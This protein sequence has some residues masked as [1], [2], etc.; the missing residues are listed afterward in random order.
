MKL[1]KLL[2]LNINNFK[3][4]KSADIDFSDITKISG[5]NELGKS[6]I[7]DSFYWLIDGKDSRGLSEFGIKMMDSNGNQ[8][9]NLVIDVKMNI[10]IDGKLYTIRKT[11]EEKWETSI[12]NPE[13]YLKGNT[14]K[15]FIEDSSG[16][17]ICNKKKCYDEFI[18]DNI[19]DSKL[20]RILSSP[21]YFNNILNWRERRNLFMALL[22]Q[23]SLAE[24]IKDNDK[25][26]ELDGIDVS[27]YNDAILHIDRRIN[28]ISELIGNVLVR[29]DENKKNLA[30][31][32]DDCNN[33]DIE[34]IKAIKSELIQRK[35]DFEKKQL[36]QR[37]EKYEKTKKRLNNKIDKLMKQKQDNLDSLRKK[38]DNYL[39]KKHIQSLV[40]D[41]EAQITSENLH[42]KRLKREQDDIKNQLDS[43][44]EK[45]RTSKEIEMSDKDKICKF[46]GQELPEEKMGEQIKKFNQRKKRELETIKENADNLKML[47]QEKKEAIIKAESL[48]KKYEESL[49]D[50]NK[51]LSEIV[52]P[53][54]EDKQQEIAQKIED[55]NNEI[56]L[57]K[58]NIVD[59][60]KEIENIDN[61]IEAI[62]QKAMA[63]PLFEDTK[64]RDDE[65]RNEHK[66]LAEKQ[67]HLRKQKS[68]LRSANGEYISELEN[69]VNVEL[70]GDTKIQFFKTHLNGNIEETCNIL[71]KTK[72]G[73]FVTY[74]YLNTGN[75]IN[76]GIKISLLLAKL[77]KITIPMFIDNAESVTSLVKIPT[78]AIILEHDKTIKKL[79]VTTG[80]F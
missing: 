56:K 64:K 4:I 35:K 32:L 44:R 25:Y 68:L 79:K 28:S 67:I 7:V 78:Q 15:Y 45:Y 30:K 57:L 14:T 31:Y 3:G 52:I 70:G 9:P 11:Q 22:S 2:N 20:I 39:N 23:K 17:L 43:L 37:D 19:C 8:I 26:R 49:K 58:P 69:A 38:Q 75:K 42:I 10:S 60:S 65:L 27:N 80:G 59:Y 24:F 47:Y 72:S 12:N 51:K 33:I 6:S 50:N 63:F 54:V 41:D 61:E 16:M 77:S 13:P 76:V 53:E 55:I 29:I 5:R 21:M 18:N 66:S 48:I 40:V 36:D 71:G 74:K 73:S 46:C 1:V 34:E 62:S